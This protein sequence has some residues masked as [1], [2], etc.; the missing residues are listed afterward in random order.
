MHIIRSETLG[1]TLARKALPTDWPRVL[2]RVLLRVLP[3]LSVRLLARLFAL[4]SLAKSLGESL[5]SDCMHDSRWDSL[6]DSFVLRGLFRINLFS[7][8]RLIYNQ[9]LNGIITALQLTFLSLNQQ[10]KLG[11]LKQGSEFQRRTDAQSHKFLFHNIHDTCETVTNLSESDNCW[12]ERKWLRRVERKSLCGACEMCTRWKV[13]QCRVISRLAVAILKT[14]PVS[15]HRKPQ[16]PQRYL[17]GYAYFW[18]QTFVLIWWLGPAS[19]VSTRPHDFEN[20]FFFFVLRRRHAP[21]F[22]VAP[23]SVKLKRSEGNGDTP[24]FTAKP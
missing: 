22:V 11:E 12:R 3:R 15:T 7:R 14:I 23:R 5:G 17:R 2:P 24:S 16:R 13:C 8:C 20:D 9:G 19:N 10:V 1:E 6:R 21:T 4:K 18:L